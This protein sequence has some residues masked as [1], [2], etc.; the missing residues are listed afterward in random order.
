M[1]GTTWEAYAAGRV[2]V[3][4]SAT[5]SDFTAG[6]TG[7]SK[8]VTLTV[9][10]MPKHSHGVK[11]RD[12]SKENYGIVW[13]SSANGGLFDGGYIGDTG[14]NQPHENMPPYIS[15]YFWHRTA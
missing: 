3:G 13:A 11:L 6:K 2:L 12:I 5:D 7:G 1:K 9:D 15:V 8:T 14:G 4:Q 10:Q